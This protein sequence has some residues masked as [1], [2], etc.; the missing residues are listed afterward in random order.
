[1][2]D[3][4]HIDRIFQERL[5]DFEATPDHAVWEQIQSELHDESSGKKIIPLWWK[6]VSVAAGLLLLMT[7]GYFTFNGSS[8]DTGNTATEVVNTDNDSSDKTDTQ[9][10]EP[11]SEQ[12]DLQI[13]QLNNNLIPNNQVATNTKSDTGEQTGVENIKNN[14]AG[15]SNKNNAVAEETVIPNYNGSTN[16]VKEKSANDRSLLNKTPNNAIAES[17]PNASAVDKSSK[18]DQLSSNK[19]TAQQNTVTDATN[20]I[21]QNLPEPP[22]S[23]NKALK[24]SGSTINASTKEAV[25]SGDT[26]AEDINKETDNNTDNTTEDA[27]TP[28]I[29]DAIAASE[30]GEENDEKE[31]DV[32]DRWSVAANVSPVYY[33]TLGKGSSIHEQ[34]NNNAKN[35]QLNLA[36]GVNAS[37]AITD[38]LS[39]RSG[40]ARVNVGYNT[41]DIVVYNSLGESSAQPVPVASAAVFRNIDLKEEVEGISIISGE[42]LAFAQVPG[43]VAQNLKST[44]NQEMSFIEIPLELEY[45]LSERKFGVSLIGGFSTMILDENK[46]YTELNEEKT[47]LG[48]ANNINDVSYSANIGLGIGVRISEKLNLNFEPNFKYQINTFNNATGDFKPYIIGINSG[49]RFKF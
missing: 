34:F 28:S 31:K 49:L 12:Q 7:I 20:K 25:A 37:Y 6:I 48:E 2:K 8:E 3:K 17:E 24:N 45:K 39:V 18:S 35:G 5:K 11:E 44:L 10:T 46:V 9:S 23:N 19:I 26:S 30:D 27:I 40:I 38:K 15:S 41:N 42:T 14:T 22:A 16:Q 1:M 36:Y 43:V 21:P 32:I 47:L 4:K 13:E 33:N 29:E